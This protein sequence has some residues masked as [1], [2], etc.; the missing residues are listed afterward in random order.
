[1]AATHLSCDDP[2]W[3]RLFSYTSQATTSIAEWRSKHTQEEDSRIYHIGCEILARAGFAGMIP[4]SLFEC[5]LFELSFL[6]NKSFL[7]QEITTDLNSLVCSSAFTFLWN[8]VN[9]VAGGVFKKPPFNEA[10]ARIQLD[11]T[12]LLP[13]KFSGIDDYRLVLRAQRPDADLQS[14]W[15]AKVVE[16]ASY[17][18]EKVVLE[19]AD[20]FTKS[21]LKYNFECFNEYIPFLL[22]RT[23][24]MLAFERR[25]TPIPDFIGSVSREA[26]LELR[27]HFPFPHVVREISGIMSSG[28]RYDGDHPW[29]GEE[30]LLSMV[31]IGKHLDQEGILEFG[32]FAMRQ[33]YFCEYTRIIE[34]L[35]MNDFLPFFSD[36]LI[37]RVRN[38]PPGTSEEE[39]RVLIFVT[40]Y[41]IF[42]Y[43]YGD[44]HEDKIPC[45]FSIQTR[46]IING[47]RLGYNQDISNR[48]STHF[49][50]PDQFDSPSPT[51]EIANRLQ[52]LREVT[53]NLEEKFMNSVHY[54][55]TGTAK[56]IGPSPSQG[57]L[58]MSLDTMP[59][60]RK[61]HGAHDSY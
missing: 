42:L 57:E 38:S 25:D 11:K 28:P 41:A 45:L 24:W 16:N 32:F 56:E 35:L 44:R 4:L 21:N 43:A 19:G 12:D 8:T 54:L 1:M 51:P 26:I 2:R 30:T 7:P 27:T 13:W 61:R 14:P 47:L 20:D 50:S 33:R 36:E 9:T 55:M 10:M 29:Q 52:E 31:K 40:A 59:S 46:Q 18:I 37:A 23:V 39:R 6:L 53:L 17:F 15:N 60:I 48:L 58:C 49:I 3:N 22:M 5:S 34:G